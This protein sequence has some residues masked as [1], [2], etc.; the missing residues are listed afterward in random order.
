M[1]D[2]LAVDLSMVVRS[3]RSL[4][5]GTAVEHLRSLVR[6][7]VDRSVHRARHRR[8]A[9]VLLQGRAVSYDRAAV[10]AG[11]CVPAVGHSLLEVSARY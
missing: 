9:P 3:A 7:G 4:R 8:Q 1:W 2:A 6:G 5:R 10:A 11:G